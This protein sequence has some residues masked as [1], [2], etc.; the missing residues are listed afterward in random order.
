MPGRN[1]RWVAGAGRHTSGW[2]QLH[3]LSDG[4]LHAFVSLQVVK[5]SKIEEIRLTILQVGAGLALHAVLAALVTS[6]A[7]G[8]WRL[9]L[10]A[11]AIDCRSALQLLSPLVHSPA[12]Q[13]MSRLVHPS[14]GID[15][16]PAAAM[17]NMM[18]YHPESQE[19][20]A[21]GSNAARSSASTQSG[22]HRCCAGCCCCFKWNMC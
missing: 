3:K 18:E 17:Q 11:G 1:C 14:F 7:A 9:E 21:W 2:Q 6:H 10:W 13:L 5:S 8:Q 20:L 4:C 15:W 22:I 12:P 16:F 19:Q